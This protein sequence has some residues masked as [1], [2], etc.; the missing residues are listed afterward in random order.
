MQLRLQPQLAD[1]EAAV[2]AHFLKALSRLPTERGKLN[3]VRLRGNGEFH[4][5]PLTDADSPGNFLFRQQPRPQARWRDWKDS[6]GL[7]ENRTEVEREKGTE[8]GGKEDSVARIVEAHHNESE[9]R[10]VDRVEMGEGTGGQDR[11]WKRKAENWASRELVNA[12]EGGSGRTLTVRPRRGLGKFRRLVDAQGLR[13][14]QKNA[15]LRQPE[16]PEGAAQDQPVVLR[17]GE[18]S[19]SKR[20]CSQI[21]DVKK[22]QYRHLYIG[23]GA[24]HLGC[25]GSIWANPFQV[26]EYGREGAIQRFED[27]LN[28]SPGLQQKLHQLINKVL[29]C[30]V[31]RQRLATETYSPKHGKSSS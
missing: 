28:S 23:R 29:L 7:K 15:Q 17:K 9:T 8:C 13:T 11:S 5:S 24:S 18:L 10:S 16:M 14:F 1:V 31:H 2:C 27:H 26:K 3:E 25:P 6:A 21:G 12:E 22:L 19:R 30:T 4:F 20:T